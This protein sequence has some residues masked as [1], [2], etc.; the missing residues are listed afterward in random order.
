MGKRRDQYQGD[1]AGREKRSAWRGDGLGGRS[2][3]LGIVLLLAVTA[4]AYLNS[5]QGR[6]LFDDRRNIVNNAGLRR[7]WPPQAVLSLQ[8]RTRAVVH[9]SLAINHAIDGY[10]PRGYHAF[11]LAVHLLAGLALFGVI[12]RTLLSGPLRGRFG[13]ASFGLALAVAMIW[14]VHP[15]QTQSVTY[16]IQRSESLMGLFY[17]AT[18]YCAIRGFA[19]ARPW[20]W[21]GP[22]LAAC[23][24]GMAT[25]QVMVTAPMMVL[26]YD[27]MF[28]GRTFAEIFRRR[29]RFYLS[30]AGTWVLLAV[31]LHA[32]QPNTSAGWGIGMGALDY[33]LTQLGVIV[34]YLRLAFWPVG[35]NLDWYRPLAEGIGEVFLPGLVVAALLAATAWGLARKKAWAFGGAWFFLILAPTSSIMPIKDVMVEHRMYLPL[36]AVVTVVVLGGHSLARRVAAPAS[37]SA[38]RLALGWGQVAVVAGTVVVLAV[39]TARRNGLYHDPI[40]MWKDV[41][42]KSPTNDRAHGAIGLLY[43]RNLRPD[44]GL[45]FLLEAIRLKPDVAKHHLNLGITLENLGRPAEAIASYQRALE[46]EPKYFRAHAKLG[47]ALARQGRWESAISHLRQAVS[48]DPGSAVPFCNLALA[49]A[50]EGRGQEA[51]RQMQEALRRDPSD[52]SLHY[53]LAILLEDLGREAL[54]LEHIRMV[55]RLKKDDPAMRAQLLVGLSR[56]ARNRLAAAMLQEAAKLSPDDPEVHFQLALAL[57]KLGRYD[58]AAERYRQALA[59]DAGHVGAMNNLAWLLATCPQAKVR[60]GPEAVALAERACRESDYRSA[61][62]LD[63]LGAAYAEVGRFDRAIEAAEKA[64]QLTEQTG[65]NPLREAVKARLEL[66]RAR[67]PYRQPPTK[68]SRPT[69]GPSEGPGGAARP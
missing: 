66:Y 42:A 46:L 43:G 29:W 54:A 21:F 27:W 26:L 7:L 67:R 1:S 68:G 31:L 41:A 6:F 49:L 56:Q 9:L 47:A 25:K 48:L 55:A 65:R 12:R 60:N 8:P 5:F 69:E 44:L 34:A 53:H 30:L 40:A 59:L 14:M 50:A 17:L 33:A 36:A 13:D 22:S 28:V 23:A 37:N 62:L 63:T 51:L 4:G 35:Q 2:R 24:L 10:N 32:D 3:W 57:G 19:S 61:G 58:Q 64:I 15:L 20:R 18:L 39:L 45:P 52:P 16:V 11:N 38:W